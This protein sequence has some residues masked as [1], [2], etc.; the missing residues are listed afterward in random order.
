MTQRNS[1][2]APERKPKK[3]KTPK[4]DGKPKTTPRES[5]K[6]EQQLAAQ[7]GIQGQLA[8]PPTDDS[9]GPRINQTAY[10]ADALQRGPMGGWRSA[11]DVSRAEATNQ[12][13]AETEEDKKE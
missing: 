2:V 5:P 10:G 13:R 11:T 8:A 4:E 1:N 7:R 3:Q 12:D 6:E 9:L